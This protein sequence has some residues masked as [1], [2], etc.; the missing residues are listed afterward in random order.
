MTD[1]FYMDLHPEKCNDQVVLDH[2][3][4]RC[5]QNKDHAGTH[6][7]SVGEVV[8][9]WGKPRQEERYV[10]DPEIGF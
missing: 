4:Y 1:I 2:N 6:S 5:T 9:I 8:L 10:M 7:C 3:I